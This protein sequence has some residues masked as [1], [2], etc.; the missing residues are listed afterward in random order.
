MSRLRSTVSKLN[1]SLDKLEIMNEGKH[2]FLQ[3]PLPRR[4][5]RPASGGL[6]RSHEITYIKQFSMYYENKLK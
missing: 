6:E 3:H 1:R 5:A 4:K 2:A